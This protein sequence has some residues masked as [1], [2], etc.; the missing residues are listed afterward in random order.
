VGRYAPHASIAAVVAAAVNGVGAA[1]V[2]SGS[3]LSS[4][5]AGVSSEGVGLA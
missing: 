5:V 1:D 4:A 2:L 3:R